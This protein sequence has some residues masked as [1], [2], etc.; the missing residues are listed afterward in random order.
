MVEDPALNYL[1]MHA[2]RAGVAE[3]TLET[4]RLSALRGTD[5]SSAL[6]ACLRHMSADDI[7]STLPSVISLLSRGT[8]LPTRAGTATPP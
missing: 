3:A 6:D 7:A 5:A 8:G 2:G 4:A 1:Q